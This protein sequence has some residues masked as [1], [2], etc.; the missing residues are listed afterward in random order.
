MLKWKEE[1]LI[2]VKTID[3]QHKKLFEIAQRAYDLLKNDIYVDKYDKIINILEE[4][5]EYAVYH[6]NSEEHYMISIG[7]RKFVSHKAEHNE[8]INKIKNTDLNKIDVDQDAYLLS[9]LEF[10]VNWT[11][12]HI[13]RNDKHITLA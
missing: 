12:E 11:S 6:F 13:L 5:K 8:F 7:Y 9:I 4:L 1:Y 10:I 2:G 3:E